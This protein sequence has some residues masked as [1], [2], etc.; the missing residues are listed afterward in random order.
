MDQRP[1]L[2]ERTDVGTDDSVEGPAGVLMHHI[3]AEYANAIMT[4]NTSDDEENLP[5]MMAASIEQFDN[6]ETAIYYPPTGWVSLRALRSC[7]A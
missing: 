7:G 3:L 5:P 6:S 4:N 2:G 1:L